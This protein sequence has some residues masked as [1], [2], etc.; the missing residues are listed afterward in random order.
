[1]MTGGFCINRHKQWNASTQ[2]YTQI[3]TQTHRKLQNEQKLRRKGGWVM[4]G[5]DYALAA[6]RSKGRAADYHPSYACTQYYHH[7]YGCTQYYHHS[8]GCRQYYHLYACTAHSITIFIRAHSITTIPMHAHS[9][10]HIC[11]DEHCL[12]ISQT[13]LYDHFFYSADE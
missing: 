4:Q 12:I 3:H 6:V 1:M 13:F 2:K 11:S 9:I 10:T 7:P 5:W 8:Y